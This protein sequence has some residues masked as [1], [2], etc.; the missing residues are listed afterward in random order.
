VLCL[1]AG[2]NSEKSEPSTAHSESDAPIQHLQLEEITSAEE[3]ATVFAKEVAF[4]QDQK[5]LTP[6]AMHAIHMSTY[7]LEKAVAYY[8]ENLE[9]VQQELAGEIAAVVEEIHLASENNRAEETEKHVRKLASLV[10]D[11][12]P[13]P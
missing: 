6:G 13:N 2:C 4:I 3:A 7:S 11:F 12:Q 9:D 1:L 8:A 10:E 5:E